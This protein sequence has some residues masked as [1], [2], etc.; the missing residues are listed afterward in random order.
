[1]QSLSEICRINTSMQ[2]E[3]VEKEAQFKALSLAVSKWTG[4]DLHSVI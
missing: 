4:L 3:I 2:N 1:M